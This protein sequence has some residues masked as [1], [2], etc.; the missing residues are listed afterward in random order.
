MAE[1]FHTGEILD[2]EYLHIPSYLEMRVTSKLWRVLVGPNQIHL[3]A[4]TIM[5]Q[6]GSFLPHP[7]I[8]Q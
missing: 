7:W 6:F 8:P 5:V 3:D 4:V 1:D 2:G